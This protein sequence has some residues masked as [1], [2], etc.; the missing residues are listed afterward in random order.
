MERVKKKRN[1]RRYRGKR[2]KAPGELVRINSIVY[3]LSGI[4]RYIIAGVD[5]QGDLD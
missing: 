4:K 5:T 3:F 2:G 1:N